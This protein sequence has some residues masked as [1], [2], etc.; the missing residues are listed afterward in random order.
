MKLPK[1]QDPQRYQGLYIFD[2]QDQIGI[3]YTA[4][5]IEILLESEKYRWAKI[6]KVHHAYP[7]G[8]LEIKGIPASRFQAESG[9]FFHCRDEFLARRDYRQLA[10]LAENH[11]FPCRAKLH[12]ST[13]PA[14]D[15]TDQYVIALIYPAEYEDEVA[16]W[17]QEANYQGGQSAT[18]G[19]SQ[20]NDYYRHYQKLENRQLWGALDGT[21][22]TPAEIFADLGKAVV[23]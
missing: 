4:R 11:E 2:F 10:E 18:G 1:L 9:I 23:R 17:L 16:A 7:D 14:A 5:E 15:Q 20:I 22:R 19:I 13:V 3:G 8:R 21:A 12:L 6:Y